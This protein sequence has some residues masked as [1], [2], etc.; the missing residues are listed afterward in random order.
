[1]NDDDKRGV[2]RG[3][4]H[5]FRTGEWVQCGGVYSDDWGE[6]MMLLQG[7]LF[8]GNPQMGHTSWTLQGPSMGI[9]QPNSGWNR[10]DAGF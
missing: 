9:R 2:R 3:R 10:Y 7:D 6:N 1:M 5:R 4:P 8:P